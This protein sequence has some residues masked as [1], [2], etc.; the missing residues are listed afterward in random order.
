MKNVAPPTDLSDA[1]N[2]E[3]VDSNFQLAGNYLD[4]HEGGEVSGNVGI[5]QHD[6]SVLSGN[7][8]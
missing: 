8:V 6:L 7:I 2:K 1:V 5:V 3:Y 4:K